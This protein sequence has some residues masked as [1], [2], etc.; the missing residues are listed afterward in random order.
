MWWLS[1]VHI[2]THSDGLSHCRSH[3]AW[4][5]RMSTSRR[6]R[7][8]RPHRGERFPTSAKKFSSSMIW[9]MQP[10]RSRFG[11]DGPAMW[12]GR[13]TTASPRSTQPPTSCRTS[14]FSILPCRSLLVH[15]AAKQIRQHPKLQTVCLISQIDFGP[16]A[17]IDTAYAATP[18]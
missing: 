2:G 5:A 4:R 1:S 18:S 7:E 11:C 3:F 13:R 17:S 12:C 15:Q 6:S 9:R 16:S 14:S 10:R 8:L